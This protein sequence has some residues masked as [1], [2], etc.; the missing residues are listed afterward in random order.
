MVE[1]ENGI[2]RNLANIPDKIEATLITINCNNVV[3]E[4]R[5]LLIILIC[6]QKTRFVH[7]TACNKFKFVDHIDLLD[8]R[9][10]ESFHS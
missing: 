2:R 6:F 4:A 5:N 10:V 3:N 7:A 1:I 8:T 9:T